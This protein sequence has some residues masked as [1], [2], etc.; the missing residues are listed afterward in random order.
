MFLARY[1]LNTVYVELFGH[2][3]D[4]AYGASSSKIWEILASY[5]IKVVVKLHAVSEFI[6]AFHVSCG[7]W[8]LLQSSIGSEVKLKRSEK[9]FSERKIAGAGD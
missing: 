6:H 3:L 9:G 1:L 2:F 7:T 8:V 4:G 5:L